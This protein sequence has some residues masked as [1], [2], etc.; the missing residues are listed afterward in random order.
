M[1]E[2]LSI[3]HKGIATDLLQELPRPPVYLTDEGKQ[4]FKRW[5]Q[6]LIGAKILKD[7]HLAALEILADSMGEFEWAS[8]EIKKKNEKK[9]GRGYVQVFNSGA[10]QIS[11]ELS[12]KKNA[13][14]TILQCLKQFGMDPKSEKELKNEGDPQQTNLLNEF[15]QALHS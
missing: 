2:V 10:S 15:K 8:R 7:Q 12:V 4:H 9:M 11:A 14:K 1:K 13:I 3:A 5:G 6:K